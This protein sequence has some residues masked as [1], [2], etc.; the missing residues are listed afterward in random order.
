MI[1]LTTKKGGMVLWA[2]L[3]PLEPMVIA[4]ASA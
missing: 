1:L 3:E 4:G 2:A